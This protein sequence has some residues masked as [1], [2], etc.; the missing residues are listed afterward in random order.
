MRV[1][2]RFHS[3]SFAENLPEVSCQR[4]DSSQRSGWLVVI[5]LGSVCIAVHDTMGKFAPLEALSDVPRAQ[6]M[7]WVSMLFGAWWATALK[8]KSDPRVSAK[9]WQQA[10]LVAIQDSRFNRAVGPVEMHSSE[11]RSTGTISFNLSFCTASVEP[12]RK[13]SDLHRSCCRHASCGLRPH[14]GSQPVLQTDLRVLA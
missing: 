14:D 8:I 9:L 13:T 1:V 7:F 4:F 2:I 3:G 6:V 5:D 12:A 10:R 11:H